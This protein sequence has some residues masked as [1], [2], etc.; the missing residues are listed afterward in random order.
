MPQRYQP[1]MLEDVWRKMLQLREY[2]VEF[3]EEFARLL[4]E[5]DDSRKSS[6]RNLLHYLGIRQHDMRELQLSLAELGLSSLGRMESHVLATID[7]VLGALA[8]LTGNELVRKERHIPP[9]TF[10]EGEKLLNQCAQELL[11][12]SPEGRNVRLMV[13]MPSEAGEDPQVI[14]R[15]MEAGMELVRINCAHDNKT[16]WSKMLEYLHQA[17]E[18]HGRKC[19]VLFDL[20]GPKLRTGPISPLEGILRLRPHRDYRGRT[21]QPAYVWLTQVNEKAPVTRPPEDVDEVIPLLPTDLLKEVQP[22]DRWRMFDLRGQRRQFTVQRVE[23]NGCLVTTKKTSYLHA[24]TSLNLVRDR[25]LLGKARVAKLP[26]TAQSIP[27]IAGDHLMLMPD[28]CPGELAEYGEDGELIKP[29]MIGCTLPEVFRDARVRERIFFDDG[30]IGGKIVMASAQ[31]LLVEIQ[32]PVLKPAKLKSDKGINLPDTRLNLPSITQKD[33]RDLDFITQHADM[34]G[35]SFVRHAYD[36]RP[37]QDE[38]VRRKADHLGIVLKIET[39]EAFDQFPRLLLTGLRRPPLGVMIARG[40]LGV[41]L[42]FER[43]A[44][45]QEELLWLCEVAHVPVIWATQVLESLAKKG[46]PSRAEVTDAAMSGRAECVMLNKGPHIEEA[47]S[48]LDDVLKRMQQHQIKK[49]NMLRPL[50]ISKL[51]S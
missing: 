6:A 50:S 36:L 30:K 28:N 27:L 43:L 45:V 22:G 19:R 35:L 2:A 8:K 37:L 23:S 40:D 31:M 26:A 25:Q 20:A 21:Q 5:V 29:A 41:E 47:I 4:D 17:E 9:C 7:S 39:K 11:G 12:E 16:V 38:L 42:G 3:E 33:L 13:T 14:D 10:T 48:F 49:R 34:V 44:E 32:R 15:Y 46:M 1:Q 24:G 51:D 18:K